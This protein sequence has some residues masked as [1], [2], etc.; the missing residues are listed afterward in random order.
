M[1]VVRDGHRVV[2]FFNAAHTGI[3]R[4]ALAWSIDPD[5]ACT[6]A[7]ALDAGVEVLAYG[8]AISPS[9]IEVNRRLEFTL[10]PPSY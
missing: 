1:G 10:H 4:L 7:E 6:L 5:Y 3:H 9:A 2:L 8:A